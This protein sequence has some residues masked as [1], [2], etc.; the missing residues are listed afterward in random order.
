MPIS[1]S[2]APWI[3]V[4]ILGI[5]ACGKDDP[6]SSE[7]TGDDGVDVTPPAA[8]ID[9]HTSSPT[10][11][12]IA[13]VW[14]A[15]GDDG[16]TGT[17][18]QYDVRF[19]T[20]PITEQNWSTAIPVD[21]VPLPKPAGEIETF[22]VTN[23]KSAEEYHFALRTSDE[24]PNVSGLS[25]IASDSTKQERTPPAAITDLF[26]EGIEDGMFRLTWTAPGDDGYGGDASA[27][28]IRYSTSPISEQTWASAAHI[29]GE[30]P[31]RPVGSPDTMV[32]SGL[33]IYTD[34]FFAMKTA[35]EV[36]NW[37]A[38]SNSYPALAYGNKLWIFPERVKEGNLLTIIY[39]TPESGTSKL[40]AHYRDE[41]DQW[42]RLV[43]EWEWPPGVYTKEWDFKRSGS[44]HSYPYNYYTI[45]LYWNS[46]VVAEALTRLEQ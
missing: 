40:H 15:P 25:N 45:K 18:S 32:V 30:N 23:L 2:V 28:D 9:L 16:N 10:T 39:R 19:S 11:T 36:P 41:D 31:P 27:Y 42:A 12:S 46:V 24:V 34:Y 35:D 6:T 22:T 33:E 1:K 14:S 20:F 17:A 3:L 37:S 7:E 29:D 21:F 26:A 13:L 5:I 44:Y 8:V 43:I 4:L 38:I